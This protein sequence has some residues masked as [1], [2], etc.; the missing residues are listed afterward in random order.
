[1]SFSITISLILGVLGLYLVAINLFPRKRPALPPGP[2]PKFLIGNLLDLPK[3]G[4]LEYLHW[5][6]H[7][8][9]YGSSLIPETL[10]YP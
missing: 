3:T 8:S 5:L 6:K 10:S 4:E 1:M 2:K 9:L 7:K